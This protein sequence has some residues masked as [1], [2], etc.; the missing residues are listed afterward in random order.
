MKLA[1]PFL[2]SILIASAALQACGDDSTPGKVNAADSSSL[3]TKAKHAVESA[4]GATKDAV[5]K[6]KAEWKKVADSHAVDIDKE[7]A[8]L[9]ESA[10]KASGSA[11]TE[12]DKVV[13]DIGEQRKVIEQKISELKAAGSDKWQAMSADIDRMM[14]DLKKSID[15]A[16]E[17]SK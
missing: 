15:N 16:L 4:E 3:E 12:L 9:K 6:A 14:S 5:A 2:S 11:K 1:L 8:K 13:Q 7:I 17:K 10:A